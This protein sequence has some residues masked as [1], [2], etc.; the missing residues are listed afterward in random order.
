MNLYELSVTN[1]NSKIR[2]NEQKINVTQRSKHTE[3]PFKL[4]TQWL[5]KLK[6]KINKYS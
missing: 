5:R 2:H 1:L 4:S 3:N 6:Q